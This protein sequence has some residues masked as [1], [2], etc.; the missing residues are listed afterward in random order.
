LI[1]RGE[2]SGEW[3]KVRDGSI[4]SDER[5]CPNEVRINK[6]VEFNLPVEVADERLS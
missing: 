3:R 2:E 5:M 1:E 4:K 6:D